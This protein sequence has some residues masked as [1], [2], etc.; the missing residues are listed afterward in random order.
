MQTLR[1]GGGIYMLGVQVPLEKNPADQK[2][3]EVCGNLI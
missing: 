2:W 3:M 1:D